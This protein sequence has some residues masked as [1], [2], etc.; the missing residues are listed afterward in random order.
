MTATITQVVK[1]FQQEWTT[2]L[3]PAAILA[4][5][6]GIDYTWRVRLLNP[7]LTIQLFFVQVLNGNTACTHLRHLTKVA[8][9]ASAYCQARAKL[10][11]TVFKRLLQTVSDRLQSDLLAEGQGLGHRTFLVDGSSFS[12]PDT[13]ELQ[14]HFGQPGGQRPGCGCPV[15]HFL[16][17][18]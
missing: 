6:H 10:P 8:V 9:S 3:E 13:P 4:A 1:Q 16:E 18:V 14:D 17:A 11:L 15:A 5:C 12:M 7:V 2:Q